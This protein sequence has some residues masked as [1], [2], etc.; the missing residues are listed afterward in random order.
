MKN[1]SKILILLIIVIVF[2][3]YGFPQKMKIPPKGKPYKTLT[4]QKDGHWTAYTAPSFSKGAKVH[5]VKK[6]DTLWDIAARYLHN[7]YLWPQIWEKN[8]YIKNP[9]WI[10]PGDPILI[11]QPKLVEKP[12]LGCSIRMGS[13]G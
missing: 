11:E 9:H 8:Q 4:K 13:P 3:F 1:S 6:G 10:Y 7:A 12:N 5:I 2:S